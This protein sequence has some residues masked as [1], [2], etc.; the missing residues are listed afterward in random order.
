MGHN[1]ARALELARELPFKLSLSKP[2]LEIIGHLD[3]YGRFRYLDT[4]YRIGSHDLLKLD[5]AVWE[6]RLFCRVIN[7]TVSAP[8]G[9]TV[10]LLAGHLKAVERAKQDPSYNLS[11]PGGVLEKILSKKRH[12][13]RPALVWK[14]LFFN[15]HNRKTVKWRDCTH[16]VNSPLSL[17]PE[18]LEEVRKYVWLPREVVAAYQEKIKQPHSD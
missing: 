10:N 11:I 2:S 4:P 3:T 1:L 5:R 16:A 8:D 18:L 17:K 12:P 14:N 9:E 7:H 15:G 6:I 13:A